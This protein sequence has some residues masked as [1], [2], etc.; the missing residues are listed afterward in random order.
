MSAKRKKT[1]LFALVSLLMLLL[2]TL[3]LLQAVHWQVSRWMI[4]PTLPFTLIQTRWC[5]LKQTRFQFIRSFRA[6]TGSYHLNS[7]S[8]QLNLSFVTADRVP[9]KTQKKCQVSNL[10][11]VCMQ[12]KRET[13]RI[14][15]DI[16]EERGFYCFKGYWSVLSTAQK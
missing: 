5:A 12:G 15:I 7:T 10:L 16:W 4:V 2:G 6:S 3:R 1:C 13:G 11:R 9:D 8:P 14:S